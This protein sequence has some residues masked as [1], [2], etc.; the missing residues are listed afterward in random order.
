MII[1]DIKKAIAEAKVIIAEI[2]EPTENVFYEL[3][4]AH[5]MNKP[6]VLISKKDRELPF[7]IS[8]YRCIIYENTVIGKDKL[9]ELLKNHLEAILDE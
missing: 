5:G 7:D 3:G 1:D 8:G 2:T 9:V 4:L 6:T